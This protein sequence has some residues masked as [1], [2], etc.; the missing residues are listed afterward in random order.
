MGDEGIALRGLLEKGS[1]ATAVLRKM[2]RLCRAAAGGVE[3]GW[4]TGAGYGE[5]SPDRLVQRNGYRQRDR[6]N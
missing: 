2:I 6:Q 1:G 3:V 4:L 5:R